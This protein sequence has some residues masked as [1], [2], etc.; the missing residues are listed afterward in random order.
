MTGVTEPSLPSRKRPEVIGTVS[1]TASGPESTTATAKCVIRSTIEMVI[2]AVV[3]IVVVS[4][5]AVTREIGPVMVEAPLMGSDT[6]VGVARKVA[7]GL[8]SAVVL[9]LVAEAFSSVPLQLRSLVQIIG[10]QNPTNSS[11]MVRDHIH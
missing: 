2:V 3:M 1:T 7:A 6:V 9:R 8:R 11:E 10:K 4:V 5:V